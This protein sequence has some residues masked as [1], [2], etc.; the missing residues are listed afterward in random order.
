M[1]TI[2][3]VIILYF[4]V[5]RLNL[6]VTAQPDLETAV[7]SNYSAT[8]GTLTMDTMHY[9][10]GAKSLRWDW[11][12]GD[13]LKITGL[14]LTNTFT[15]GINTF[16][17]WV[18]A[19]TPLV[20]TIQFDFY[21]PSDLLKFQFKHGIN[22]KGWRMAVQS[23]RFNMT[24]FNANTWT[25]KTIHI[26]APRTGSGKLWFDDMNYERSSVSVRAD[27][28]MPYLPING[29]Y[30]EYKAT[31]LFPATTPSAQELT[32]LALIKSRFIPTNPF[33][34]P[35]AAQLASADATYAT[36][37][38]V[39]TGGQIKGKP[40]TSPQQITSMIDIYS[41]DWWKNNATS[42][43]KKAENLMRLLLDSG[44]AG[45]S[46]SW[47][48]GGAPGYGD[49]SFFSALK[50]FARA[51]SPETNDKIKD[52]LYWSS[53]I[54]IGW[55]TKAEQNG[56]YDTDNFHVLY[57]LYFNAVFFCNTDAESVQMLKCLKRY[58]EGFCQGHNGNGDGPKIDGPGF[59]HGA[60]HNAYMYAFS[61]F[62]GSILSR[63]HQTS[64]Q[65]DSASYVFFRS[66][67]IA[68]DVSKNG[69]QYANSLC[70]RAPFSVGG[71][72]NAGEMST[73]ANIGGS[74]LGIPYDPI[75]AAHRNWRFGTDPA[76]SATPPSVPT[77]FWQMNYSPLGV[78]R[79]GT[80]V[81]DIRGHSSYF[82]GTEIYDG[83][84]RY[85]R[86]QSFGAVEV[87]YPG[88]FAAS[89]FKSQG[90]NWNM[91]PGTTTVHLPY[92]LLNPS[93][94]RHDE[95]NDSPFTGSLRFKEI[96]DKIGLQHGSYGVYGYNLKQRS[97][98]NSSLLRAKKSVFC[99]NDML[100]CLG[101]NIATTSTLGTT[102][103]NLYQGFLTT[104]AT[105]TSVDGVV[106]T[107]FPTNTTLSSAS[108]H[109]LRDAFG[110]AYYVFS[111][112][113][114]V[115]VER[116]SQ[117]TPTQNGSG[118]TTTADY[119]S[120]YINHGTAPTNG[121]Y[122]Y[123]IAPDKTEAQLNLL[124]D[125]LSQAHLKPYKILKQDST[126]HII[127]F[128][129]DSIEGS[130]FFQANTQVDSGLVASNSAP[131]LFMSQKKGDTLA[132]TLTNP[133]VNLVNGVSVEKNIIIILR[134][135]WGTLSKDA[136]VS[137]AVVKDTVTEIN[138]RTIDGLP[139][140]ATLL[141]TTELKVDLITNMGKGSNNSSAKATVSGG[142]GNYTYNW[143]NGSTTHQALNLG[144]GTYTL[145]VD[146]GLQTVTKTFSV[147]NCL[148]EKGILEK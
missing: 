117:T 48:A 35:S 52:W 13:T 124:K 95:Y 62:N 97:Y 145:T 66:A 90:W 76:F 14:N 84:N 73:L 64:F 100:I 21:T 135:A 86:Y 147:K 38:I 1:L 74:I 109:W 118:A 46:Q 25:I 5:M 127:Y 137:K 56:R 67:I 130:V 49:R 27:E 91:P 68:L 24:Q 92:N 129:K 138:F 120:A 140:D 72:F 88:G 87:I 83:E 142:T 94:T 37:N 103:T 23:Y 136:R 2:K 98:T 33:S 18:Y 107:S 19:E 134:G 78:Y 126:A 114:D 11:G 144:T 15:W 121:K 106:E 29:F 42:S 125:T 105:P 119:A 40:I 20:D 3:R 69:G 36:F 12:G 146:D 17:T 59:H 123:V 57:D 116:K 28:Q 132:I 139:L 143:S 32:D 63:L 61:T 65:I 54:G 71:G 102:A 104:T 93:W 77:G 110:T 148:I 39:E 131:T 112:G 89:G 44:L 60:H 99:I 10:I 26:V 108:N 45:G 51:F 80:W 96:D 34:A 30:K 111:G 6:C 128:K 122:E 31:P 85:G 8:S 47:M 55:L 41:K 75:M 115:V 53:R 7:P 50:Y 43:L 82:W 79:H 58:F 9:R 16:S 133:D 4:I 113:G 70:G 22:F 81:A 141:K 101:T